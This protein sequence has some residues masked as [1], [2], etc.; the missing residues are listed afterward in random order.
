MLK[1]L[2]VFSCNLLWLLSCLPGW[3]CFLVALHRPQR[4]Q[5]RILRRLLKHNRETK[6]GKEH[7]FSH[8]RSPVE[9][10]RQVPLSDYE[11]ISPAVEALQAGTT[12]PFT[13]EKILLL[14]PTSGSSSKPKLI[15]CTKTLLHEFQAAID[16]W[17]AWLF[18]VYP[19]ILSGRHYW[20]ISPTTPLH[21]D[22]TQAVR[23]GFS[24]D[25][26]YLGP[27]GSLLARH[28]Q[29]V[30]PELREVHDPES[31]THL[32]LLFLLGER[33]LRLISIWHPSFLTLLLDAIP[34]HLPTILR[35]L[36]TGKL[37]NSLKIPTHLRESIQKQFSANPT[38]AIEIDKTNIAIHPE[39]LRSAWP[40]LKLISCWTN[41]RP[42]P[43]LSR[44]HALFPATA[45]QGKGLL[46]TEGVVTLPTGCGQFHPCAVRSHYLE[47]R[48]SKT[49]VIHPLWELEQGIEYTIVL[50]TG[51][52]L[53]RYQ[54]HD[55]VRVTAFCKA[56]PCLE[57]L[58]KEASFSDVVG[59]K[60]DERHVAAALAVAESTTGWHPDF[61]MLVPD[62]PDNTSGK[63]MTPL[64]C[65]YLLL[66]DGLPQ[67]V[68]REQCLSHFV[69]IVERELLGNYHY[70]HAL[71][72]GQLRPLRP[73]YIVGATA[74][75]YRLCQTAGMRIG[76]V[77]IPTLVT[78]KRTVG[79]LPHLTT[80]LGVGLREVS[81]VFST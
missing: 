23:V 52:G 22:G 29:V 41:G 79:L 74:M 21:R 20:A 1:R 56:T 59:E 30:P 61:A 12:L 26:D 19:G 33:D 67:D 28:L 38:R 47:F 60:L 5:E 46:A 63:M 7:D 42:E 44:I 18:I 62:V 45:I 49:G 51:G 73:V 32:T 70:K 16:P 34:Q 71:N 4:T 27:I 80:S 54:L 58:G 31:F 39:N 3:M 69:A 68:D 2:L 25:A 64:S 40:Q 6:F 75:Y 9:F 78:S 14:E 35:E 8:I 11:D 13:A 55:R 48:N 36:Q 57:F 17:I 50:T 24:Q 65:G 77:K 72:M 53:W 43:W 81:I 66:L 37:D 76:A 15:P 10:S